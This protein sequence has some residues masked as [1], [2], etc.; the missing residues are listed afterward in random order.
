MRRRDGKEL[1]DR[2]ARKPMGSQ[3][4]DSIGDEERL[5][6]EVNVSE[7]NMPSPSVEL[8]E[9]PQLGMKHNAPGV[10]GVL[11]I[12]VLVPLN[13]VVSQ[14]S[15]DL[16]VK[17]ESIKVPLFIISMTFV[18]II[19]GL[20][21]VIIG[22]VIYRTRQRFVNL[23][24]VLRRIAQPYID[25]IKPYATPFNLVIATAVLNLLVAYVVP[26]LIL[27]S[28]IGFLMALG[29]WILK[30]VRVPEGGNL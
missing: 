3:L 10:A 25:Q 2:D 23:A 24:L 4:A 1:G 26:V 15:K 27:F 8:P 14:F 29:R 28:I 6:S 16:L 17:G 5:L 21:L 18:R 22:F 9:E 19:Y 20:G 7:Q 11:P 12:R 13:G 30:L